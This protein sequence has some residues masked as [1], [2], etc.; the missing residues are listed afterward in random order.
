[1]CSATPRARLERVTE[2]YRRRRLSILIATAG[3][4][5]E[6]VSIDCI[7][8]LIQAGGM[9]S[10]AKVLQSLGRGMRRAPGKRFFRYIDFFDD[11]SSGVLRA[12]SGDRLRALKE[13]GFF[14]P[15]SWL[16]A[17]RE[18]PAE[19]TP[20]SWAHVPGSNR[21]VKMDEAGTIYGR[22]RCLQ[23]SSVPKGL[24]RHCE[25]P[26]VCEQGGRIEWQEQQD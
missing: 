21:F 1:M 6:G 4:F 3:L 9:K 23:R 17:P 25:G 16:R 24:C 15:D 10:R 22:A 5:Q 18:R 8:A 7:E 11:D 2:D 20:P 19:V 13:A 12:H 26:R 14:V